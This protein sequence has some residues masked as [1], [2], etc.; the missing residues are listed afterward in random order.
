MLP[1]G[2][3]QYSLGWDILDWGTTF[4][5]QPDGKSQGDPWIYSP[6]QALFILWFYAIDEYGKFVYR[7]GVL[8][9][10]KGWGK[11][12]LLAAICCTEFMGPVQ[13]AGWDANGRPVGV[14][15][16]TPLVQIAAIS[17]S[18]AENTY[19]LCREMMLQGEFMNAYPQTEVMLAKST[20]P[21]NR[22]LEKVTASPRGRE[23]NRATFVVMDETHLWV[24]AERGPELY[25][26]LSRNLA[27]MGGR[28]IE[29]TNAPV[30]GQN[31]VAER[32]HETY[33]KMVSGES[34]VRGLL[35]DTREVSVDDIYDETQAIPALSYVYGDS[36]NTRGGWVDLSRVWA[37]INDPQY[38][39][40][41]SR[42][43]WFNQRVRPPSAW[44]NYK[45]WQECHHLRIPKPTKRDKFVIG[46]K[47]TTNSKAAAIVG[48]RL[49]DGALF[50]FG[51][52]ERP[53]RDLSKPKDPE[54]L[55]TWQEWRAPWNEI[56][57]R[58]RNILDNLDVVFVCAEPSHRRDLIAKWHADYGD[59][60]EEFWFSN[61][62][63]YARA[64]LQFE[65]QVNAR[66]IKWEDGAINRHVLNTHTEEVPGGYIVRQE[67]EHSTRY[68][69]LAQAA[70][71]A[72]EAAALAIH[73]GAI[74]SQESILFSY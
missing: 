35:F 40:A 13:F 24:P 6:E 55:K 71:L 58:M 42:R 23:G 29:T 14:P 31:S 43:F 60:V 38:S 22:K 3:P 9:R 21:G 48:V 54:M 33:E 8:E 41:V 10:P 56:D 62:A 74:S 63:K 53:E 39:E 36:L 5:A 44:L 65:D 18:Q 45:V 49:E 51:L 46:F 15:A 34:K 37:E 25:E 27:K 1:E 7:R 69:A 61:R 30:P 59:H 70:I 52:W 50:N 68:I 32:T 47:G 12:P 73:D 2:I 16:P 57:G 64:C 11:S 66:N 17:D 19:A 4:L 20:Y 26:A 67:T 72:V 28:F